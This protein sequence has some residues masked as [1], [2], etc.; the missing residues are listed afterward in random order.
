MIITVI[1]AQ[2]SSHRRDEEARKVFMSQYIVE[3]FN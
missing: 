2:V 1:Y 3:S